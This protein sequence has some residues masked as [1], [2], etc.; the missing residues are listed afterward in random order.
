MDSQIIHNLKAMNPWWKGETMKVLPTTKR[1]LVAQIRKRLKHHIAPIIL[2]KGSRQVGKTTSCLQLIKEMLDIGIEANRIIRVQ[3]DE[4][5]SFKKLSSEPIIEIVNWYQEDIL[6]KT[7]NDSASKGK[8]C[9]IFLD[10]VQNLDDWDTQLKFLVDTY[11]V[12]VIVTG[13]SALRIGMGRDSLAGRINTLEV[14]TLS[15]TEIGAIRHMNP[16]A[17]FLPDNG[18]SV[19]KDVEFWKKLNQYG[20]QYLDFK[21]NAFHFFTERGAYPIAHQNPTIEWEEVADQLNE[22]VIQRVIQHDLRIGEKG[23]KRDPD[24]LEGIFELCCRYAGQTPSISFLSEQIQKTLNANVGVQRVRTYLR[25]LDDT[26]LI[27]LIKPLEI[28][29]KRKKSDA[30]I[31]LADYGLRRSWLQESLP[32]DS[33]NTEAN[34]DTLTLMG[35]MAESIVGTL[36]SSIHGLDIAHLPAKAHEPEIDFVLVI[37]DQRIPIEV[38]YR[39]HIKDEHL[40]GL[41]WFIDNKINRSPF[42]II[43]VKNDDVAIEDDRI[44]PISLSTLMLLK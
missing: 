2:V 19:F 36:F 39:N 8:E 26:L 3:F 9:F 6:Q 31:C 32:F 11:T 14:G 23:R 24:L 33:K 35:F 4:I 10:E 15:L 21:K 25:F 42:G 12:N 7:L 34:Q 29:L 43:I 1:H 16:P 37:G 17:P 20:N 13:S 40:K 30:K 27:K 5:P 28:R 18:L 41:K 38:K 44:I 22:T